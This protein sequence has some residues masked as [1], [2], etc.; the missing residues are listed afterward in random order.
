MQKILLPT[1][2]STDLI[3]PQHVIHLTNSPRSCTLTSHMVQCFFFIHHTRT[4]FFIFYTQSSSQLRMVKIKEPVFPP[5]QKKTIRN[6][7]IFV[8]YLLILRIVMYELKKELLYVVY[9]LLIMLIFLNSFF[10]FF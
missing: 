9:S 2:A 10:F 3:F 6:L 8:F 7:R 4:S 5:P 1:V